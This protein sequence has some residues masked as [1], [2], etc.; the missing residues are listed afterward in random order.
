MGF[1]FEEYA[2]KTTAIISTMNEAIMDIGDKVTNQVGRNVDELLVIVELIK[3]DNK[4]LKNELNETKEKL[5]EVEKISFKLESISYVLRNDNEGKLDS[6]KKR[7]KLKASQFVGDDKTGAKYILFYGYYL[8]AI[9]GLVKQCAGN[10]PRL[11]CISIS[12]YDMVCKVAENWFPTDYIINKR[13]KYLISMQDKN[14]LNA[15]QSKSL[16]EYLEMTQGGM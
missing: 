2:K 16:D 15:A 6:L 1:N 10:V 11:D 9:Q 8:N 7:C 13:L 5:N 14:K 3:N 4:L 12:N